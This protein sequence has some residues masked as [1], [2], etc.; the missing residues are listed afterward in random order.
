MAS[1]AAPSRQALFERHYSHH[2]TER[3]DD[4]DFSDPKAGSYGL[5]GAPQCDRLSRAIA[6]DRTAAAALDESTFW[7]LWQ[8]MSENFAE[9]RFTRRACG[10]GPARADLSR[11]RP[12]Q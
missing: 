6:K 1:L 2:L 4:S 7:G 11:A 9:A 12:S 3:F 8:I 10:S 5:G